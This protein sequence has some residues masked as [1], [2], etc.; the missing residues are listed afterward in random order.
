[1]ARPLA[2]VPSDGTM[3]YRRPSGAI[4][5]PPPPTSGP[6][7]QFLMSRA[8]NDGAPISIGRASDNDI[9]I[10]GL[11]ISNHHARIR[12]TVGNVT[13]EDAGSTNGVFINGERL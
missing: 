9:Q 6:E 4:E 1:V 11:L 7:P 5:P 13:I 3:V 10:D 2:G 8:F 12:R